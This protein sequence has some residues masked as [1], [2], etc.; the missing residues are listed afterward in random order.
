MKT[1][2]PASSKAMTCRVRAMKCNVKLSEFS[3]NNETTQ[4]LTN[5]R[6][7]REYCEDKS[8]IAMNVYHQHYSHQKS[9][10]FGSYDLMIIWCCRR[11]PAKHH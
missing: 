3:K 11:L 7:L 1:I 4:R 8:T 5:E 2:R 6:H 10:W 9:A